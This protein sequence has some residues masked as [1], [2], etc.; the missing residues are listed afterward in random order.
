MGARHGVTVGEVNS[1]GY[2][3]V[4]IVLGWLIQRGVGIVPGTTEARHLIENSPQVLSTMP[5]FS[6]RE[7]LD[8]EMAVQAMIRGEDLTE[9]EESGKMK[10]RDVV[11][12]MGGEAGSNEKE[13]GGVVATFFNSLKRNVRIFK[14]HPTTGRQIQLSSS[15]SPG[16]SGRILVDANDVLIAY[17]GHGVAVKKFLVEDDQVGGRVDFA[18]EL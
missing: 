3:A 18:V 15:I 8:V 14:V 16:R 17:D 11:M 6:P 7:S 1:N 4:Q 10:N 5:E 9:D 13:S 2:S 12:T